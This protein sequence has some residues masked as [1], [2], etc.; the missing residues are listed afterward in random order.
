MHLSVD[1]EGSPP[2]R[3]YA[4][5]AWR[6]E[7]QKG[8]RGHAYVTAVRSTVLGRIQLILDRRLDRQELGSSA[9]EAQ[10]KAWSFTPRCLVSVDRA[11]S[12]AL[13]RDRHPL[14]PRRV[15]FLACYGLSC[16]RCASSII[17]PDE[18][19]K[20]QVK[21][22]EA[23]FDQ[24]APAFMDETIIVTSASPSNASWP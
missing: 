2:R 12:R 21:K 20:K 13:E 19:I 9:T 14:P 24:V 16:F 3:P 6:A 1:P 11:G 18:P 22:L 23:H 10:H 7:P 15:L 17:P 5:G 4:T 8:P